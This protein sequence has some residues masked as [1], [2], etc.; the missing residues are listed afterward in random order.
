MPKK[1]VYAYSEQWLKDEDG[2]LR[3]AYRFTASEPKKKGS[4]LIVAVDDICSSESEARAL[5]D[6][7]RRNEISSHHVMDVLEDWVIK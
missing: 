2:T 6:F 5:V 3:R 7:F 4:R 1:T